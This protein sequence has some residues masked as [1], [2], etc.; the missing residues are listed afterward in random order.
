MLLQVGA[1]VRACAGKEAGNFYLIVRQDA[2]FVWLADGKH[3]T[4]QN[5]KR[6][7][8][9]HVRPTS[10]VWDVDSLTDKALRQ[11]LHLLKEGNKFVERRFD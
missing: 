7:N 3:R 11:K 10:V 9:K 4:L 1:V 2:D 6:K 5:P 8:P